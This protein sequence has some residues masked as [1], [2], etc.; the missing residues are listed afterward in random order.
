ML[1]GCSM[2]NR[3]D[4]PWTAFWN[5]DSGLKGFKDQNGHIKI[6]PKYEG[7]TPAKKFDKIIA[8]MEDKNGKLE[9]Y[10][11]TKAGK[12]VGKDNLYMFDNSP[13]CESEGFIRFRHKETD[14]A[15][16]YNGIG[17]IVIPAVYNDLTNVQNGLVVALDG[18]NKECWDGDDDSSCEHFSWVGGRQH[19]INTSNQIIIKDFKCTSSLNFFSLEID[20]L[21][22]QD[23]NRQSFRGVDGRYYTFIDYKEEF[24][25]WLNSAILDSISRERLIEGSYKHIYIFKEPMG[26]TA[27]PGSE[28]IDRNFELIKSRLAEIRK[29]KADYFITVEGLNPFIYETPEFDTYFNNCGEPQEWKYPVMNLTINHKN[30]GNLIQDIFEFLRTELGYKLISM[31]MR[32]GELK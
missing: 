27:E 17:E 30:E 32:S 5:E 11:L 13:D 20:G 4:G 10:Y 28:L 1:I 15:G 16:M 26:W 18:A 6:E 12:I 22:S 7:I 24:K 31:T 23:P 2:H 19:L 29:Q 25:F 3:A 21:P 14:K 8:V 9:F